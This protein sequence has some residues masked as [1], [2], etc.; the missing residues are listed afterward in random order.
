M[1]KKKGVESSSQSFARLVEQ[2]K[3][4]P[5]AALIARDVPRAFGAV[6]PHKRRDQSSSRGD[7]NENRTANRQT[8]ITSPHGRRLTVGGGSGHLPSHTAAAGGRD[9][10]RW[11]GGV[12]GFFEGGVD[13]LSSLLGGWG[14][15]G[16]GVNFRNPRLRSR[17]P[18]K[19]PSRSPANRPRT[20]IE[21]T[22]RWGG[23]SGGGRG[24]GGSSGPFSWLNSSLSPAAR[25]GEITWSS[26]LGEGAGC[27]EFA[28]SEMPL[29]PFSKKKEKS[30]RFSPSI[31]PHAAGALQVTR[32]LTVGGQGSS[33]LSP[34][35]RQLAVGGDD[36]LPMKRRLALSGV[37]SSPLPPPP[38]AANCARAV[39]FE[40]EK[41]EEVT[42]EEMKGAPGS[43]Y[44][45][46]VGP[47]VAEM[48]KDVAWSKD[49]E[50][51]WHAVPVES[52]RQCL[53]NVL[54]AVAAQFPDVGY[55]QVGW[56]VGRSV[57]IVRFVK[58]KS[59]LLLY[60][61]LR[62]WC[63]CSGLFMTEPSCRF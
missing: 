25:T 48:V 21:G 19:S 55:C 62:S 37:P 50:D 46:L 22:G 24:G 60:F 7:T 36:P 11:K 59:D 20:S 28:L 42:K 54:L 5:H 40:S 61:F 14:G 8:S 43:G 16:H 35:S 13:A 2:G 44:R 34:A 57:Y 23:G 1:P 18:S 52:K 27:D 39:K 26:Q 15:G 6:A 49:A 47:A 4:G 56:A 17:P 33:S 32:R 30:R 3:T 29:S 53:R 58:S 41:K 45:Q 38:T 31:S 9:L 10:E 51:A 63:L 12:E